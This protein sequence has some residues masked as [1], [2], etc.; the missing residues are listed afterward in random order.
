M[1]K[2]TIVASILPETAKPTTCPLVRL[3]CSFG[4]FGAPMA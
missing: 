1:K 3:F 4:F 2:L